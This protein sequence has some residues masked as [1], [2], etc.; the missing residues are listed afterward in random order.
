MIEVLSQQGCVSTCTCKLIDD[1]LSRVGCLVLTCAMHYSNLY[2]FIVARLL[3]R[4]LCIRLMLT[5]FDEH[6]GCI[7]TFM[8][9]Q[10]MLDFVGLVLNMCHAMCQ[11]VM[12]HHSLVPR[13]HFN[14]DYYIHN[15]RT[16]LMDIV[17][18]IAI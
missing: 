4:F 3:D 16:W 1:G 9:M 10:L 7:S 5:R 6:M 15:L 12:L 18:C 17:E 8:H 13:P 14:T 2:C 11:S